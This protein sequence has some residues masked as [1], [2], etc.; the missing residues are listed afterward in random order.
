MFSWAIFD[1][2][3]NHSSIL[4]T[5]EDINPVN[6]GEGDKIDAGLI[7]DFILATHNIKTTGSQT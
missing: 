3:N 5:N 6:D 1:A 2:V 4:I 7:V